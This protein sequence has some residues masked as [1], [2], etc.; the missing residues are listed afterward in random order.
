MNQCCCISKR[1]ERKE[2][3]HSKKLCFGE[4]RKKER[5]E[6]KEKKRKNRKNRVQT[7]SIE[8]TDGHFRSVATDFC[9]DFD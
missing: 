1:K 3:V 5:K 8:K 6:K 7:M 2:M 9:D 4:A